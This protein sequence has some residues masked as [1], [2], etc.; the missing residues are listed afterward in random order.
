VYAHENLRGHE[1]GLPTCSRTVRALCRRARD[2]YTQRETECR[3]RH[4][5]KRQA[6]T[7]P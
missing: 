6:L 3:R 1:R 2:T 5:S 4:Q 7:V